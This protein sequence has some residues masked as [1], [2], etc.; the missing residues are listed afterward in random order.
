MLLAGLNHALTW[1]F[2]GTISAQNGT[3]LARLPWAGRQHGALAPVFRE[4][5]AIFDPRYLFN[6]GKVIGPSFS[7]LEVPEVIEAVLSTYLD[8]R[9]DLGA[10]CESFI[11]AVRRVGL[12]PFKTAADRVRTRM[13]KL[14]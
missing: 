9:A 4:L 13:E 10:K 12:D 14:A 3:G 7:A 1:Q 8:V 2:G 5:K 6:P 11:E